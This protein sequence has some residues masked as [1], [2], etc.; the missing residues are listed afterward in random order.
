[1][2]LIVTASVLPHT[3]RQDEEAKANHGAGRTDTP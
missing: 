2:T 1:M 3:E